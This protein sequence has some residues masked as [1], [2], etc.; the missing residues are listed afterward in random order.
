M[1][2]GVGCPFDGAH[3]RRLQGVL[4][5]HEFLRQLGLRFGI[6]HEKHPILILTLHSQAPHLGVH[7][8]HHNLILG[9][10]IQR[11][12]NEHRLQNALL[13][14]LNLQLHESNPRARYFIPRDVDH[15]KAKLQPIALGLLSLD[16]VEAVVVFDYGGAVHGGG[17]LLGKREEV[18]TAVDQ[19][20]RDVAI[21]FVV[22]LHY[23]YNLKLTTRKYNCG[24]GGMVGRKINFETIF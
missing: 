3:H 22:Y 8:I 6:L 23:L 21:D 14:I 2:F 1:F 16:Y 17:G 18:L 19:H 9:L 12:L 5:E 15:N 20:C 10:P 7:R 24:E 11:I 13:A 4:I